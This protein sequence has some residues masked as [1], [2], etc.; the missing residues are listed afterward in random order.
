MNTANALYG[1]VG[2]AGLYWLIVG[3]ILFLFQWPFSQS[4][5]IMLLAWCIGLCITM[6]LKMVLTMFCRSINYRC[7]YRIR[8]LGAALFSLGLECWYIGLG[9]SVLLSRITQFLFAAAFWVGRIDVP[10]LSED[11]C[12]CKCSVLA[13]L[14][15]DFTLRSLI[16]FIVFTQS[17][18]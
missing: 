13:W 6:G 10:F 12:L 15:V 9:A 11:I 14:V 8:P 4:F 5:M 3:L 1:M 16:S 2:S 7:F 17:W 18:I